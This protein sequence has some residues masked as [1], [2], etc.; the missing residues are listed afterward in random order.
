MRSSCIAQ[1][2]IS[3]HLKWNMMEDYVK[4]KKKEKEKHQFS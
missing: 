3:S 4:K 1:G 2:T